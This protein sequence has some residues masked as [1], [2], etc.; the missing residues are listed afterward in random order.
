MIWGRAR[1]TTEQATIYF[2]LPL[3]GINGGSSLELP[4]TQLIILR[5]DLVEGMRIYDFSK[6]PKDFGADIARAIA[7]A[8][9]LYAISVTGVDSSD[10]LEDPASFMTK[11]NRLIGAASHTI[12]DNLQNDIRV[13]Y[14]AALEEIGNQGFRPAWD[15]AIELQESEQSQALQESS[16]LNG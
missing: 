6:T 13:A 10:A 2:L 9:L 14:L 15:R 5:A 3:T 11:L 12:P 7:T 4:F 1:D 16:D 8:A